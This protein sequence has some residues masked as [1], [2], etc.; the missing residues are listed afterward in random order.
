MTVLCLKLC[1]VYI[2]NS[3]LNIHVNTVALFEHPDQPHSSTGSTTAVMI[4]D[5]PI[6]MYL[7]K[8][9][10]KVKI[11]NIVKVEFVDFTFCVNDY[12]IIS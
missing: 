11:T 3:A 6:H 1:D 9:L 5:F 12:M 4:S 8:K 2:I 10:N 7:I